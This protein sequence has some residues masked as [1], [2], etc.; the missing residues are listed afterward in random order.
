MPVNLVQ[1]NVIS[2]PVVDKRDVIIQTHIT[3]TQAEILR[4]FRAIDYATIPPKPKHVRM[5]MI[6]GYWRFVRQG[7]KTMVTYQNKANPGG[8]IPAWLV[9]LSVVD[10]P[11]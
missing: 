3:R 7:N 10:M 4:A 9:N 1:Y 2:A 11:Y 5:P 8:S 6:E